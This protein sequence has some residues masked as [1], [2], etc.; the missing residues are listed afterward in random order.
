[1]LQQLFDFSLVQ[2]IL[3]LAQSLFFCD[4]LADEARAP[5]D[6]MQ[7]HPDQPHDG[8]AFR[9][10]CPN[11]NQVRQARGREEQ[12]RSQFPA[13][14]AQ[15]KYGAKLQAD[16]EE[17]VPGQGVPE[18]Q[19]VQQLEQDQNDP[20]PGAEQHGE[21]PEAALGMLHA[22]VTQDQHRRQQGRRRAQI[23]QALFHAVDIQTQQHRWQGGQNPQSRTGRQ[24]T[25]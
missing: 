8:V 7:G 13:P 1:M 25:Q 18:V 15:R 2:L 24:Q 23:P 21:L 17:G 6:Q 4:G 14:E 12:A 20:G 3:L 5:Q 9:V 16:A 22:K 19:H 11:E 10:L